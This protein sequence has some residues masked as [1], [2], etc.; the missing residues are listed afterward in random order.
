MTSLLIS[1]CDAETRE[2]LGLKADPEIKY[3]KL[4]INPTKVGSGKVTVTAIAGGENLGGLEQIGG[5]EITRTI[6]VM[7]RG[8]VSDNGGWL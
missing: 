7:S 6:S 3:G 5:M 1:K 2:A 4:S 8:V